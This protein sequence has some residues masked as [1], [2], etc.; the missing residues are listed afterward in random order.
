MWRESARY[1]PRMGDDERGGLLA[2]W[3]QALARS[4]DWASE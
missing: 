1:E 3:R 4:R 2:R